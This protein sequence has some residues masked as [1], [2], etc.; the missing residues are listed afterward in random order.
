MGRRSAPFIAIALVGIILAACGTT[1]VPADA[2]VSQV[3]ATEMAT[4]DPTP[5]AEPTEA[6]TPT[7]SPDPT[8]DAAAFAARYEELTAELIERQCPFG[9]IIDADSG[10]PA[11]WQEAMIGI[12][13]AWEAYAADLSE[14][15]PPD[16]VAADVDSLLV[17]IAALVAATDAIAGAPEDID[18]VMSIYETDYTPAQFDQIAPAGDAIRAALGMAPRPQNPC[19]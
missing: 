12:G 6:P 15:N 16:M 9:A 14:A 8:P 3:A 11:A 5:T 13:A 10:N 4:P 2:T 17:G 7:P 19:G 1:A 18:I